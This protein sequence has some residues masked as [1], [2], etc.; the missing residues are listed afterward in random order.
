MALS[1]SVSPS[2]PRYPA[3]HHAHLLSGGSCMTYWDLLPP[4]LSSSTQVDILI[5]L[6]VL[7]EIPSSLCADR[8]LF[9]VHVPTDVCCRVVVG[10]RIIS[11]GSSRFFLWHHLTGGRRRR[12]FPIKSGV[13]WNVFLFFFVFSPTFDSIIFL[14]LDYFWVG[15]GIDGVENDARQMA[16]PR[17]PFRFARISSSWGMAGRIMTTRIVMMMTIMSPRHGGRS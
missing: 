9:R 1:H 13:V 11:L 17:R 10:Y 7:S 14:F 4:P 2:W 6:R 16:T 8:Q 3:W 15:N 12:S 5:G